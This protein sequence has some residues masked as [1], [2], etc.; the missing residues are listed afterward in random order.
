[1][2][3]SNREKSD[4]APAARFANV[5]QGK[6]RPPS[7]MRLQRVSPPLAA[8]DSL[9]PPP[10]PADALPQTVA[11][12]GSSSAAEHVDARPS[13][14]P[15]S[16]IPPP[17]RPPTEPPRPVTPS[18]PPPSVQFRGL[19]DGF[20]EALAALAQARKALLEE[21]ASEIVEL[22]TTIARR[23]IAHELTV[24]PGLV[25]GLAREGI[26]ALGQR[27]RIAVRLGGRFAEAGAALER[28]LRMS[29]MQVDI[30]LDAELGDYGCIVETDL[31]RVD[32]SIESRLGKLLEALESDSRPP[33][34]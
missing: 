12:R 28:R 25:E 15:P 13:R 9:R 21:T 23:V 30:V 2:P 32:E 20:H 7:W 16:M 27:D 3:S 18:V 10:V 8:T 34:A 6:L 33:G 11:E 14:R 26:E 24:D 31:G 4:R 17:D 19:V 1:M 22:A 5:T 29:G